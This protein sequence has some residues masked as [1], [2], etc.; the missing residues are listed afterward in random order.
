MSK[1]FSS[2]WKTVL[3]STL[4]LAIAVSV[5]AAAQSPNNWLHFHKD[6]QI[7]GWNPNETI[8]TPDT[9]ANG[10]FGVVWQS[11]PDQCGGVDS[12][13]Y[14]SPL[15]VE[16]L[17]MATGDQYDGMTFNVVFIANNKNFV[18]A[19]VASDPSGCAPPGTVLWAYQLGAPSDSPGQQQDMIAKGIYGTP[20][21]DLDS[22]PPRLY[23]VGD[24]D[25]CDPSSPCRAHRGFAID[26]TSGNVLDGWPLIF[27]DT[28]IGAQAPPGIQLNGPTLFEEIN[29][30]DERGGLTLS[31][32]KTVLYLTFGSYQDAGPGF[33]VAV[34]TGVVSGTPA[35]LRVF[36]SAPSDDPPTHQSSGGMWAPG[37]VALD[38]NGNVY[39]VTG[40]QIPVLDPPV[41][42]HWAETILVFAP[43]GPPDFTFNLIG[44]YTPWNHC[45]MDEWDADLSG[46]STILFDVDASLTSTPHLVSIG[47]K[48]GNAYLLDRDNMP[49]DL[50]TQPPC[51]WIPGEAGHRTHLDPT[52]SPFVYGPPE[53][54]LFGPE[55]HDYYQSEDGLG[56]PRPGPL[57][58]FA[59]YQED[60]H[61]GNLARGRTTP[62]Y[63]KDANGQVYVFFT[64]S[65]KPGLCSID[66]TFPSI[67]RTK[68]VTPA[69][70]Q[71]AYLAFDAY[72]EGIVFRNPGTAVISSN[73]GDF[74]TAILWLVDPNRLR[75][76]PQGQIDNQ[77]ILYAVEA[78]TMQML[79]V[80]Y[81]SPDGDTLNSG[82]YFH[83][84]VVNGMVFVGTNS[85]TA[86]GLRP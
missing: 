10:N 75:A 56:E 39:A 72:D 82:K 46:S 5:P 9:V 66:P 22:T 71:P 79:R 64:G 7:T 41:P 78:S 1:S 76:D 42:G 77:P 70:D 11:D 35:I 27:D 15:Y 21:I 63:F 38:A 47:G 43:V 34:D 30:M 45:Q 80:V 20:A 8:L 16:G 3:R 85:I 26:I 52:S 37:G 65:T 51:H 40:N 69:P 54:S 68:L 48:Q 6:D 81:R 23:V 36:A 61:Q 12:H 86:Y 25:I 18:C 84:I 32:D 28:T 74:S 53:T 31:P 13:M 19:V 73:G 17:T 60:C 2:V 59:P 44:T 49:G 58:L 29:H 14:A 83:P 4:W 67:A 57:N 50:T 62:A 24:T 55:L 33:L